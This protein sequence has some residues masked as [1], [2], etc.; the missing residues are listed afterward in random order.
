MTDGSF[1]AVDAIFDQLTPSEVGKLHLTWDIPVRGV[2]SSQSPLL[3]RFN[4]LELPG[5]NAAEIVCLAGHELSRTALTAVAQSLD[6]P[7]DTDAA[8]YGG[9]LNESGFGATIVPRHALVANAVRQTIQPDRARQVA[10]ALARETTG[11]RSVRHLLR[12]AVAWTTELHMDVQFYVRGAVEDGQFSNANEILRAALELDLA[13]QVR[14]EMLLEL[15]LLNIRAKRAYLVLDLFE[16]YQYIAP[17]ILRDFIIVMLG[18]HLPEP[19][20]DW[21]TVERILSTATIDPDE[22][23]IQAFLAFFMVVMTMRSSTPDA[24]IALSQHAKSLLQKAPTDSALLKNPHLVWMVGP[25]EFAVLLDCN[26]M[27]RLQRNAALDSPEQVLDQL[28]SR[29]D[30]LPDSA[31]KID[32]LVAIAG[33]QVSIGNV[34]QARTLA[35]IS[36]DLLDQGFVPFAAG[37][38]RIILAHSLLL[39]G[40]LTQALAQTNFIEETLYDVM[41]LEVRP[42][43]AALQA[44]LLAILDGED[45]TSY[46]PQA[47]KLHEFTWE[48]YG[49]DLAILAAC[50]VAR[51][52]GDALAVIAAAT[53]PRT[54]NLVN[55][56]RGFKTYQ[57]HALLDLGRIEEAEQLITQLAA[58]HGVGW[59]ELW[60]TL[61]GLQARLAHAQGDHSRAQTLFEQATSGSISPFVLGLELLEY[62]RFLVAIDRHLQGK[63]VLD[64][65]HKLLREIGA[66]VYAG[67]AATELQKNLSG[68]KR[69]QQQAVDELT[70]RELEVVEHLVLGRPNKMIAKELVV[71]EATIRFHV[72]NILRKLQATSRAEV[73]KIMEDLRQV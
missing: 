65:A 46:L 41:D 13:Q 11:F 23:T 27:V 45:A 51:A 59:L 26:E 25:Q 21:A 14:H 64:R 53:M 12:G 5:R 15:A 39:E 7:L 49:P 62:G 44:A 17:S 58:I 31:A 40:K 35:Q 20:V 3:G 4:A 29:V 18:A 28:Q 71:S 52:Q 70:S 6:E 55:T 72:S 69:K 48:A 32:C 43:N 67:W 56:K 61:A 19:Q 60:G 50:E 22:Q 33:A 30:Q 36:A 73:P 63:E 8:I 54:K 66:S 9:V 38:V 2:R 42:A 34:A 16:E 47:M 57:A 24:V 1:L 10:Q 68:S 37:T